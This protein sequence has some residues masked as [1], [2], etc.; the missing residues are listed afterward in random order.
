MGLGYLLDSDVVIA[1]LK[2][3]DSIEEL[4]SLGQ[5]AKPIFIS[6]ITFFEVWDGIF[7]SRRI[8]LETGKLEFDAFVKKFIERIFLVDEKICVKAGEIRAGLRKSGELVGNLDILIAATCIVNDLT[9]VT[10][11]KKHSS[12]IKELR[13]F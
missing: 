11:N 6:V 7:G 3:K 8:P 9:L 12:R 10:R 4:E 5:Q 2:K 13:L 1:A